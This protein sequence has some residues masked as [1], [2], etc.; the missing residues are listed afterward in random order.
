MAELMQQ[1]FERDTRKRPHFEYIYRRL[2]ERYTQ[3]QLEESEVRSEKQLVAQ[4]RQGTTFYKVP[5]LKGQPHKRQFRI[6]EDL[7]RLKWC[8]LSTRNFVQRARDPVRPVFKWIFLTEV[9]DIRM[10]MMTANFRRI[11]GQEK[12]ETKFRGGHA[13]SIITKD[14]T[15]DILCPTA[16]VMEQWVLGLRLL[17]NRLTLPP[18]KLLTSTD[19]WDALAHLRKG[20]YLLKFGH[21]GKPHERYFG[22]SGNAKMLFWTMGENAVKGIHKSVDLTTVKEVRSV[23]HDSFRV[24]LAEFL[25]KGVDDIKYGFSLLNAA[26]AILINLCAPNEEEYNIW[27]RGLELIVANFQNT[28]AGGITHTQ[29]LEAQPI[30]GGNYLV[31]Q[32]PSASDEK[33]EDEEETASS[34]VALSSEKISPSSQASRSVFG[35]PIKE[36][37]RYDNLYR[38]D[39]DEGMWGGSARVVR[40]GTEEEDWSDQENDAVSSDGEIVELVGDLGKRREGWETEDYVPLKPENYASTAVFMKLGSYVRGGQMQD[41]DTTN[42][43]LQPT[44]PH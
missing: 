23:S 24:R 10:G 11:E 17:V 2:K 14:R 9:Q 27:M 44:G 30:Y 8:F 33:R 7:R 26:G 6:S 32:M 21:S 28:D 13:F 12:F 40:G 20:S 31:F 4:L 35:S 18:Q 43:D 16:E 15:V 41:G 22:V 25:S 37:A 42:F 36:G 3:L 39:E 38:E 29:A 34:V 19:V 1:C 5:Y